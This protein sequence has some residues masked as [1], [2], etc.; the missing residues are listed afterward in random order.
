MDKNTDRRRSARVEVL[1]RVQG[2]LVRLD[3]QVTVQ[4][5]S[6][7]GMKIE[8][9]TPFEPGSVTSF[10]LTLGDGAGVEVFGKVVYTRRLEAT[11]PPL[12]QSGIQFVDQDD[13][14]PQSNVGDL[15]AKIH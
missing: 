6:L 11:E 13:D 8:T 15:I 2:Q 9:A 1:G 10:L 12:Y 4:E 5:M 14:D 7:G 3:V